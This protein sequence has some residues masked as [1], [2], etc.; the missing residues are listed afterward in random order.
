VLGKIGFLHGRLALSLL[1]YSP[2]TA[3][4]GSV[5]N[6]RLTGCAEEASASS[7]ATEKL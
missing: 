2:R 6:A 7:I 1:I 3:G 5:L 4:M